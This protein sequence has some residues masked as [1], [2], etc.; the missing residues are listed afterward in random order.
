M[1]SHYLPMQNVSTCLEEVLI[2][3]MNAMTCGFSRARLGYASKR[4]SISEARET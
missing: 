1:G 3:S 2:S 4:V